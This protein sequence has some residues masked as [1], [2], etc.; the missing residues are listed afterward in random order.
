MGSE[1]IFESSVVKKFYIIDW[2]RAS[3]SAP[4]LTDAL[5]Y[6]LGAYHREIL[7]RP[8][9]LWLLN[10]FHND[11]ISKYQC[12]E[13]DAVAALSY[14]VYVGFDLAEALADAYSSDN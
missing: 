1:N 6:W 7:S 5:G 14:L 12:R 4:Y 13:A 11:F 3:T 8:K 9:K 10:L 2:E